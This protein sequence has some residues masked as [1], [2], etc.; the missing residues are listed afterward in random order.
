MICT[1]ELE[2]TIDEIMMKFGNMIAEQI[3]GVQSEV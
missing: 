3:D 2:L 1:V